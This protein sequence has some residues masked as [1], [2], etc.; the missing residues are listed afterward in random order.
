MNWAFQM[1]L[2]II[3]F[4]SIVYYPQIEDNRS[5][6]VIEYSNHKIIL[7]QLQFVDMTD[8]GCTCKP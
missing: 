6:D 4:L 7:P 5:L 1:L 2:S 8:L 3:I